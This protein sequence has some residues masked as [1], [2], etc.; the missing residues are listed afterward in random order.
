MYLRRLK[1]GPGI[2]II[3]LDDSDDE[4]DSDVPSVNI[5]T[6]LLDRIKERRTLTSTP[7]PL[8]STSTA[9]VLFRPLTFGQKE[10][11][12]DDE[13]VDARSRSSP[14]SDDCAMDVE[15]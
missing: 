2:V 14:P 7:L 15:P 9:L 11:V 10:V 6:A 5:S 13:L 3:D 1:Y 8:H 4:A 12:D